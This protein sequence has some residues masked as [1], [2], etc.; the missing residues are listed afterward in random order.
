[1]NERQVTND[2]IEWLRSLGWIC[3]RQHVGTFQPMSG[4]APVKM[5]EAGECDWRCMR[6]SHGEYVQYFE[7]ELK[8]P[9]KKP[10]PDQYE[11]MA[12][13]THQG[14]NATWCDSLEMLKAWYAE[15]YGS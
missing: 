11:Y 9:G 12:K 14:F 15:R 6:V 1:M 8:A 2:C 10:R 13:R 4:G 7:L 5:G 3:R